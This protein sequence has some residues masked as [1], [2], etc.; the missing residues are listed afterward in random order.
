[1]A[2]EKRYKD[3]YIRRRFTINHKQYEVYAKDNTEIAEKILKKRQELEQG[4]LQLHN[5]LLNDYYD[6]FTDIRRN[7]VAENTIRAQSIQYR[8]IAGVMMVNGRTFGE[9]RIKDITRRDI[10]TARQILLDNGKTP[11]HLNI[12]FSHLNHVLNCAVMDDTLEKNPCKALKRLKRIDKPINETKHRALSVEET[13]K[14]FECAKQRNSVYLNDFTLMLQTGLRLGELSALYITDIDVKQG[15]IHVRRT[16]TRDEVGN[17]VIGE[18]AKTKTGVRDIPLTDDIIETIKAQ[19]QLNRM[20]YGLNWTGLLFKSAEGETLRDT[21]INREI[22]RICKQADIPYFTC[23][24]FRNTFATRF[25][26]QRPQD[27]KILSEILGHKDISITLNLY[28]HVMTE[29]KVSAM[30]DIKVFKIS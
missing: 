1:M 2:K 4:E 8:L 18:T 11:Q 13:I 25:I 3:K 17:Y 19:E 6:H 28:T 21:L 30:N 27:Y 22:E 12:A 16:I 10:E 9:I 20:L 24:A 23:H 14:F 15:F 5:P 26:E 7:E 29:N